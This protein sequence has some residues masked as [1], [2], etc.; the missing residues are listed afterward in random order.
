MN[1]CELRLAVSHTPQVKS[2]YRRMRHVKDVMMSS[3]RSRS[4]SFS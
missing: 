3:E 1:I 4:L 2:R